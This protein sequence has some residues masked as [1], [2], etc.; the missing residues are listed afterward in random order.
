MDH[1]ERDVDVRC[2]RCGAVFGV[3]ARRLGRSTPCPSCHGRLT[4]RPLA[5]EA[6]LHQRARQAVGGQGLDSPRLPIVALLDDVRSLWNVGSIFRSADAFGVRRVVLCGITGCPPQPQITKTALGAE[7][8]V[9]WTYAVDAVAE[10]D[11]LQREGLVPV[12]LET[13]D[14][15][16]ALDDFAWPE[17]PC[18]VLGNE[19]SGISPPLLERCALHVRIPML[20]IKD[21][22]NVAVAFGIAAHH[23]SSALRATSP[24]FAVA[25]ARSAS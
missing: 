9:P 16:V 11:E 7:Q 14:R 13:S 18:L 17:R 15:A 19:V 23:A 20:G 21:S 25:A 4:A 8:T 12:A 3:E 2:P 6:A 22:L 1:S 24:Q 10:L 5:L